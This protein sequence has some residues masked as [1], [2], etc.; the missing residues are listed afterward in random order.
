QYEVKRLADKRAKENPEDRKERLPAKRT[1]EMNRRQS[2]RARETD[3]ERNTRLERDR[4]QHRA[5]TSA[6]NDSNMAT[7]PNC[8]VCGYKV[9]ARNWSKLAIR[10][11][12]NLHLLR[13][14]SE[15]IPD[16][17]LKISFLRFT[18]I[19]SGFDVLVNG[20]LLGRCGIDTTTGLVFVCLGCQT[21]LKNNATPASALSRLYSPDDPLDEE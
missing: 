10:S 9:L 17:V 5:K 8:A 11:F 21:F 2:L 14:Q 12:P 15:E 16:S 3:V 7:N 19:F 4:E 18:K 20:A 1:K 13:P 6:K